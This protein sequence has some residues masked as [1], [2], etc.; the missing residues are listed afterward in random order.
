MEE[1]SSYTQQE[2][3]DIDDIQ[4]VLG[5]SEGTIRI[6]VIQKSQIAQKGLRQR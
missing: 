1:L 4:D 5:D 2:L 6:K 3:A